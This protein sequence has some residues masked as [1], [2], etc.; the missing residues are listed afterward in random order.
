ML[1]AGT[2]TLIGELARQVL[3]FRARVLG[4]SVLLLLAKAAAVS[5]PLVLKA[6]V[7]AMSRPEALA[8]LPVLLLV[9]YAGV[10]FAATLFTE[11]RDLAFA[12]VTQTVV[13]SLSLRTFEHLHSL[14]AR[15]HVNRATGALTREIERGTAAVGFLTGAALFQFLPTVVEIAAVLVIMIMSYG[16]R[17]SSLLLLTFVLY[18]AHTS[19]F[20]RRR[21]V[22]QRRVT[23]L[24]SQAHRRLVDSLLNF[25]TVKSYANERFEKEQLGEILRRSI[26]AGVDNQVALT[27]LHIGQSAAIAIGIA[28]VM[29]MAGSAIVSG[30][31]SVGDLVLVNAYVIQVCLPLNSLG[32]VIRESSDALV[33][34]ENLFSLLRLKPEERAAPVEATTAFGGGVRFERVSFAY[35][36][37]RPILSA[38]AGPA[39]RRSR[40]C[41][42]SCSSRK[43]GASRSAE[44]ISRTSTRATCAR[45]WDW[46]PRTRRCSTTRSSTTS[47][48]AVSARVTTRSSR[49]RRLPTYTTSYPACPTATRPSSASAGSSC[50]AARSSA[51]RSRARC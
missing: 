45:A 35:E 4:A 1:D 22:R 19:V 46:F 34:A 18:A 9:A 5:V 3:R 20:I 50:P 24:E 2:R 38:G 28:A 8:A 37:D 48:M 11:L 40:G 33:R 10:R 49:P 29:L 12:R 39:S 21:A 26:V 6:I 23:T 32:F 42:S 51:S 15:F 27:Q 14:A 17:F 44:R 31:L 41:C 7:D 16:W 30:E 36:P 43:A 25:E 47:P 13:S